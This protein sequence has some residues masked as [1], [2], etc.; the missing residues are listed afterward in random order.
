MVPIIR[1]DQRSLLLSAGEACRGPIQPPPWDHFFS[2]DY[3]PSRADGK[4]MPYKCS[5]EALRC[6]LLQEAWLDWA[7]PPLHT[8][9]S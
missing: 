4:G 5:C 7:S 9:P 8:L 6:C 2:T 3:V 1:A